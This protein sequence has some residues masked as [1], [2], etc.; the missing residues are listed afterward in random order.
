[1]TQNLRNNVL[2]HSARRKHTLIF[3]HTHTHT[4]TH[5]HAHTHTH[6]HTHHTHTHTHTHIHT[7]TH[8]HTHKHTHACTQ[9][10]THTCTNIP[11]HEIRTQIMIFNLREFIPLC[12]Q[13]Q[14]KNNISLVKTQHTFIFTPNSY[15]FRT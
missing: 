2:K 7:R 3:T 14:L 13:T 12:I 10:H 9:T 11:V 6:T 8:T 15:T 1:M 5:A 4:H